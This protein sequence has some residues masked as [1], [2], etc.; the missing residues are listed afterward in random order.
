MCD[1][2]HLGA[3]GR[4]LIVGVD[5][6]GGLP[7]PRRRRELDAR[8]CRSR[9]PQAARQPLGSAADDRQ[10]PARGRQLKVST[11]GGA[12][13]AEPET[14]QPRPDR[15]R[16]RDRRDEL[17]GGLAPGESGPDLGARRR[18]A[19][20]AVRRRRAELAA[21]ERLLQRQ[22]APELVRRP[23]VRPRRP[24]SLRLLHDRLR[25][26]HDP[27]PRPLV[28]PAG[29]WSPGRSTSST[30]RS[31]AGRSTRI[32]RAASSSPRSAR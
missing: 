9:H 16:G 23:D 28:R 19:A 18:P 29:G 31:T 12:S 3:D 6:A 7:Q 27:Q 25:G 26:G 14:R 10:L 8:A 24:R 13:F 5:E 30:A 22:A 32:R 20:L 2:I 15:R 1:R 21:G 17:P 11:D 4:T